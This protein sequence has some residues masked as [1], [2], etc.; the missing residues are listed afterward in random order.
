MDRQMTISLGKICIGKMEHWKTNYYLTQILTD[1]GAFQ[2]C[3]NRFGLDR[4]PMCPTCA[5]EEE[6]SSHFIFL[7]PWFESESVPT[8]D[9]YNSTAIDGGTYNYDCS[10]YFDRQAFFTKYN[11]T[12]VPRGNNGRM[13]QYIVEEVTI[14][15]K[16][17][18]CYII[19]I[20][21]GIRY[22]LAGPGEYQEIERLRSVCLRPKSRSQIG[23]GRPEIENRSTT[24][25]MMRH[26]SI[27]DE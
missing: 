11:I 14:Q 4:Q 18:L 12:V 22:R 15:R 19:Q 10:K 1:Q 16:K 26:I 2:K 24:R 6:G 8:I 17:K 23:K 5:E 3:L 25:D 20:F 9:K 27:Y 21:Q 7:C 13:I